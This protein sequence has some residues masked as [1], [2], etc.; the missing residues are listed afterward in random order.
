MGIESIC[1]ADF[2]GE[3]IINRLLLDR[4]HVKGNI[5][6]QLNILKEMNDVASPDT[7]PITQPESTLIILHIS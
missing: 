6:Q 2:K 1:R 3:S 5:A 4:F 7:L